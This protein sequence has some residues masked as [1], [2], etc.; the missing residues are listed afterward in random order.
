MNDRGVELDHEDEPDERRTND[1]AAPRIILAEGARSY[2]VSRGTAELKI[3]RAKD[4]FSEFRDE[5]Q[6]YYSQAPWTIKPIRDGADLG[7]VIESHS[8]VPRF[9]P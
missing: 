1:S 9:Q 8:P 4:H 2:K 7:L 3:Q 6:D 5:L